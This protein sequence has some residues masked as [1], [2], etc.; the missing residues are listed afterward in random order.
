MRRAVIE[1][2]NSIFDYVSFFWIILM[3]DKVLINDLVLELYIGV[4]EF[5]K[6][7]KQKTIINLELRSN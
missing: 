4:N 2:N 7:F 6:R 3:S 5:E 1:A